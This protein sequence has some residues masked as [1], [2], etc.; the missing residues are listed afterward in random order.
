M[1]SRDLERFLAELDGGES[2]LLAPDSTDALRASW[3]EAAEAA[4]AAYREWRRSKSLDAYAIYR[5]CADRADAA[6]DALAERAQ[7]AA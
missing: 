2:F 4:R 3:R 7:H 6:Q 1:S 5:A